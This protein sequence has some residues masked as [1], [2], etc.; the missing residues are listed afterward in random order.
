MANEKKFVQAITSRDDDFA[1]W[2]LEKSDTGYCVHFAT[3]ATVL[4]R[5]AG[6]PARYVEGYMVDCRP[7]V[8]NIVTNQ[9]A[10]AWVEYFDPVFSVWWILEATPINANLASEIE[11]EESEKEEDITGA[12]PLEEESAEPAEI[13]ETILPNTFEGSSGTTADSDEE[14]EEEEETEE[15]NSAWESP[16]NTGETVLT[17][18]K[19]T[20]PVWI[21]VMAVSFLLS[22]AF[23]LQRYFRKYRKHKLWNTGTP[24]EMALNR[25]NQ[26]YQLADILNLQLPYELEKLALKAK[27]SQHTLTAEELYCF[28]RCRQQILHVIDRL[29]WYKKFLIYWI[30]AN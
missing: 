14:E 26:L 12:L 5:A 13:T 6:I 4:L 24:N 28:D 1:Q 30:H 2:F 16:D 21:W 23:L 15:W 22:A 25:W 18:E 7:E 3:A 11:P 17:E 27:F 8:K 10:H 9:E 29:P 19:T 20:I